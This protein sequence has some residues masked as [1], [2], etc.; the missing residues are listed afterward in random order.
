MYAVQDAVCGGEW[1]NS[2]IALSLLSDTLD[3]KAGTLARHRHVC[4]LK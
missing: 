2:A 3:A 1:P 4:G